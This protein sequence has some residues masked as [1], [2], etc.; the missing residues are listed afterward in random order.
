MEIHTKHRHIQ[1]C[2]DKTNFQRVTEW[3]GL[4]GT[5][6][7]MNLQPPPATGQVH[8]PP[9]LILDQAAQGPIPPDLEHLQGWGIHNFSGQPLHFA[10]NS[11][12]IM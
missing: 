8:Q 11:D 10:N 4:E 9:N 12:M 2:P 6:K 1:S 3:P 5:S 7:I